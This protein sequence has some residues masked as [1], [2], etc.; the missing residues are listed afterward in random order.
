VIVHLTS[1][2]SRGLF[3][4][5]MLQSPG[6]PTARAKVLPLT[7]IP[8]AE[9]IAID[10]ARSLGVKGDGP[11]ALKALR[12]FS[13]DK[14][15][16]GASAP[17]EV[18]AMS[19]GG[20]VPG[21]AGAI[22]DGKLIV[23]APEASFAAGRQAMVPVVVGAN[24]RD[25]YAA[26]AQNKDQVFAVFGPNAAEARKLYDPRGDQTL[27]ELKQQVFADKTLVEPARHLANEMARAGQPVWLYRFAYVSQAQRGKNM[28]TLHGFEIP[29]TM[30]IPA[31]MVGDKVTPTDKAMADLTSA[32]WVT[33]GLTSDPNGGG[34]PN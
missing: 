12:A 29:F 34:R 2:L 20:H 9:K 16:E 17:Q 6:V 32:Y 15:T 23:E 21:V 8:D 14:L 1:P 4:S 3:R 28:G 7:D 24:D 11:A 27:D 13:A 31:T 33:F 22:H 26:T 30:D 18:A 10:Y 25:L 5:A 19:A